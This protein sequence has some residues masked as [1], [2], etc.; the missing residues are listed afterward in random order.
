RN[1]A[2][3][4]R[5]LGRELSTAVVTGEDLTKIPGIGKDLAQKIR[6]IVIT[7][8]LAA[9]RALEA[10]TPPALVTLLRLPGLGPKRV[11]ALHTQLGV[12]TVDDLEQAARQG[13]IRE[14]PG[15]GD[16]TEERILRAVSEQ[17][18]DLGR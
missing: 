12:S 13:R 6:E 15:F 4:A 8:E 18:G 2:R 14:L 10:E 11:M 17:A 3:I 1:V 7:G 9:L 16:R 5:D